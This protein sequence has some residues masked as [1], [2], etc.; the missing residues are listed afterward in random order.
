[1]SLNV[2]LSPKSIK[3]LHLA[4]HMQMPLVSISEVSLDIQKAEMSDAANVCRGHTL[5]VIWSSQE[6]MR[7]AWQSQSHKF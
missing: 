3:L 7:S 6:A 4:P 2:G 1:M 5:G